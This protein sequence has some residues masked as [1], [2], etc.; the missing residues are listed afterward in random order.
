MAPISPWVTT[1]FGCAALAF[2]GAGVDA[3]AAA[4]A[5]GAGLLVVVLFPGV[6]AGGASG[7][8]LTS[9][10]SKPPTVI[11]DSCTS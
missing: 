5:F 7:A 8:Y 2:A 10:P 11:S 6:A 3:G 1:F 9:A 4:T